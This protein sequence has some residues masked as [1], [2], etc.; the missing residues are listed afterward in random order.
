VSAYARL[1][2]RAG[3]SW[4]ST[5]SMALRTAGRAGRCDGS[6]IAGHDLDLPHVRSILAATENGYHNA[7]V[8]RTVTEEP[9]P[10]HASRI[11]SGGHPVALKPGWR[12]IVSGERNRSEAQA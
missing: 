7:R 1:D 5:R 12:A 4:T 10:T 8:C 11:H 2:G 3:V 9:G 6:L